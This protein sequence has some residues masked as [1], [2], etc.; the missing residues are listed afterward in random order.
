M[1]AIAIN[2]AAG[3]MGRRLIAL[4][5]ADSDLNVV[6]ALE[7][8]GH[9]LLGRDSGEVAGVRPNAVP[10]SDTLAADPQVLIDFTT[11]A[12]TRRTIEQCRQH[13][14]ALVIGTTGLTEED[15]SAIDRSAGSIP[16]LAAANFSL[17]VHVLNGLCTKAAA[18]LGDDYDIEIL[19]AHHRFK[20]DAPSGTAL[21]LARNICEATG[22]SFEADVVCTRHGNDV[23]RQPR[24]ITVQALRLGDH[25]G[26]HTAYFA[27]LGERIELRHVSTSRDSYARGALHAAGWV[28]GK[29]A[30][31]YDMR[32]L[33][34]P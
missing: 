34:G 2:G 30:G 16:I 9:E 11:P 13:G 6:A 33:L 29:P 5:G 32:D 22:R 19:E 3:R 10:L 31:R 20:T 23:P 18:Q 24:Q 14:I 4:A 8:S 7:R 1:T 12:A 28:A 15:R 27:A 26:E 25:T 21:T 17:A